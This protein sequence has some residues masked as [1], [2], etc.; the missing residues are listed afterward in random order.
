MKCEACDSKAMKDE[1]LCKECYD[2][3]I[4]TQG[5]W[6][7]GSRI[8]G[9]HTELCDF[10]MPNEKG[11]LPAHPGTQWWTGACPECGKNPIDQS[12]PYQRKTGVCKE[13]LDKEVEDCAGGNGA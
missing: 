6:D 3:E 10:R 5:C 9:H 2:N 8:P 11:D 13:C 12:D 4:R 7:C 1:I